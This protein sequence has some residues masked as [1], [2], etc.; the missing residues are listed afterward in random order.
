MTIDQPGRPRLELGY[1]LSSE[2]RSPAQL[3]A[4]AAAAEAAGFRSAMIS[5]HFHPWVRA[6]GQSPFVWAV[7]GGIAQATGRLRVGTGVAAPI[8]RMHPV[9]TA[10]AAATAAVMLPGRFFLGLGTGERLNEHVT[11]GRWPG[12]TERRAMLEEAVGII[13]ALFDGE[14]VN[15]RGEHFQVENARLFTR[16]ELPPP[17]LLAA[18]GRRSAE[19]AGRVA[20]GMIAVTPDQR[21]VEAFEAAGGAGKPRLGQVHVCWAE[22]ETEA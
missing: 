20:D 21:T 4:D 9:V 6:Q 15:H 5:D 8:L 12:A 18:G 14:N 11:G 10:H 2:E 1:W 3:V 22:D 17:I 19:L 7:L 16:P 13:R